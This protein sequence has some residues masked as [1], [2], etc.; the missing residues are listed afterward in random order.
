[1]P[2]DLVVGGIKCEP[3]SPKDV[4]SITFWK[5]ATAF[6]ASPTTTSATASTPMGS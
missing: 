4:L 5:N 1:M 3:L 6:T 2:N